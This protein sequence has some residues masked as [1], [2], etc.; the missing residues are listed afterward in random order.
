MKLSLIYITSRDEP[1]IDWFLDS[2]CAQKTTDDLLEV[3]IVAGKNSKLPETAAMSFRHVLPKPTVWSG[4]SRITKCDWWSA[5]NARNTGICFAKHPS[6]AFID[7]RSVLLPGWLDRAK[8]AVDGGYVVCGT[9]QK[10]TELIVENGKAKSFVANPGRDSRLNA[11]DPRVDYTNTY[12]VPYFKNQGPFPCP[13]E[14]TY[15]C[16][17]VLPLEWAL[18]VGGF[19][20]TCEGVGGEDYIFGLML[21]NQGFPIYFDPRMKMI[22]DRTPECSHPTIIR[23]DKGASPNDKS[24]ALLAKLRVLKRAILPPDLTAMRA[25]VQAGRGFPPPTSPAVDWYDGE[26]LGQM[27]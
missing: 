17:L 20:E 14:W 8:S 24:H 27:T 22:E 5:A 1:Q 26:P 13:G 2:L 3:I 12:W 25:S 16:S 15:G 9:Y 18:R 19:D 11:V 21:Q 23:R 6:I 4:P 7:D 10:V